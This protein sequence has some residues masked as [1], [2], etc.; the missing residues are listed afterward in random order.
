MVVAEIFKYFCCQLCQL[1]FRCAACKFSEGVIM[2]ILAI[3]WVQHPGIL[4][5]RNVVIVIGDQD[6]LQ[7]NPDMRMRQTWRS[8]AES[9]QQ[10]APDRK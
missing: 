1:I 6:D 5:A 10:E 3:G 8:R 7:V 2:Q 4:N 9:N